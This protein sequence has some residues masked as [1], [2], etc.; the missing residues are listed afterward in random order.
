MAVLLIWLI[1]YTTEDV[2][3]SAVKINNNNDNS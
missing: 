1:C 2:G 3:T